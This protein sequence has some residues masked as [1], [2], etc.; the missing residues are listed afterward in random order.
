[1]TLLDKIK[2]VVMEDEAP[3]KQ[4][5]MPQPQPIQTPAPTGAVH[6][7]FTSQN[8][9]TPQQVA[10]ITSDVID[11]ATLAGTGN[12]PNDF[13]STLLAKTDFNSTPVGSTVATI[14]STLDGLGL[15]EKQQVA[16][17]L[18]MGKDKGITSAG[19]TGQISSLISALDTEKD[20]FIASIT[21]LTKSDVDDRQSQVDA[22]RQQADT[23]QAQVNASRSRIDIKSKQF[24]LAYH[25]RRVQ[26]TDQVAH[27]SEILKG[28]S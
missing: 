2:S 13:T 8:A 3:A 14:L 27:Y 26:L 23:L 12:L 25:D 20:K 9:Y 16:I 22:L 7:A 24:M 10:S 19:I 5:A 15:S 1:V 28:I 11:V 18:K 17:V 21:A 4:P 6:N